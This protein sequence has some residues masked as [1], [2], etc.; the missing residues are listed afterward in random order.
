MKANKDH[1]SLETAKLLK[2][3]GVKSEYIFGY[4]MKGT[5]ND[6]YYLKKRTEKYLFT[7]YYPAFTWNEILWE[8][9]KEFFGRFEKS[10]F[11]NECDNDFLT[12]D[13]L[14]LLQEGRY[15]K[16]DEIFFRFCIFNPKNQN[17]NR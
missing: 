3:C 1:I 7:F 9:P 11:C 8:Y 10:N 12:S 14:Q 2:D 5:E 16:A 13:I 6:G 4:S 17:D 15:D